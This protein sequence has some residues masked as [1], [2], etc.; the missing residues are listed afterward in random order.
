[1]VD[2]PLFE[3]IHYLLV[4]GFDVFGNV[5]HQLMTRMYMDFLRMEGE[6]NFLAL[7]PPARRGMLVDAWYR[8]LSSNAKQRVRRELAQLGP[9]SNISYRSEQ[10]E[11]ELFSMLEKRVAPVLSHRYAPQQSDPLL[12]AVA[13]LE[14]VPGGAASFM[15]ELVFLAVPEAEGGARYF[16]VMRDSAH[17]NVAELFNEDDRRVPAEDVLRVVPGFLGAYPNAIFRVERKDVDT[18]VTAVAVLGSHSPDPRKGADTTPDVARTESDYRELRQQFGV[19]R[20]ARDFWNSSD[21]LHGAYRAADPLEAGMFDY[22]RLE[23]P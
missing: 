3:R 23:A 10:P 20:N 15:P 1:V 17:T 5:S 22:N 21:Q 19:L 14:G 8:G 13:A 18:F 2:Y 6:A 11:R 16:T 4:A 12:T 7:L 9:P